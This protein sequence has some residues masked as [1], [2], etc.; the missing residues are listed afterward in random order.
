ME[1]SD[2]ESLK[3]LKNFFTN[4]SKEIKDE[5]SALLSIIGPHLECIDNSSSNEVEKQKKKRE[6]IDLGNFLRLLNKNITLQ[7]VLKE[8]QAFH[9]GRNKET[10]SLKTINLATDNPTS[11]EVVVNTIIKEEQLLNESSSLSKASEYWLL[12][13][14]D[15]TNN[16]LSFDKTMLKDQFNTSFEKVFIVDFSIPKVFEL[17]IVNPST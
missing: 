3:D 6:I 5:Q 2:K 1:P 16:T 8:P 17:K 7:E 12:L 4:R 15:N 9:L 11:K 10:I 14:L 13:T